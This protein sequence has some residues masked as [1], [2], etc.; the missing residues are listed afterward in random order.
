MSAKVPD[1]FI[2][3]EEVARRVGK[4]RMTIG[5]WVKRHKEG[6]P[7]YENMFP[8]FQLGATTYTTEEILEKW[9]AG[10]YKEA[11]FSNAEQY[12]MAQFEDRDENRELHQNEMPSPEK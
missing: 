7:G 12:I 9:I 10:L 1:G 2:G 3:L 8:Y 5:R 6:K 11:G 4:S